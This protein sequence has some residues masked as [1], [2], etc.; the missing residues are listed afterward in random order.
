MIRKLQKRFYLFAALELLL[1]PSISYGLPAG[2]QLNAGQASISTIA[3]QTTINQTSSKAVIDWNS[4]NI[5]SSESVNFLQPSSSSITLNRIHDGSA[6]AINGQLSANGNIWLLNPNGILFGKT[7][8]VNVGGLLATTSNI[9]NNSFLSGDYNFTSGGNLSALI[10]NE[11]NITVAESGLATIVAPNVSNSG[12]IQ[13]RLGKVTLA[14]GDSFTLDTYGDNLINLQV[15]DNTVKK[16][17]ANHGVIKAD[18]GTVTLTAAGAN[19]VVNS[20]INMDGVIEADSVGSHN[21]KVVLYAEGSNAVAGNV[22]SKK[23]QKSGTSTVLVSGTIN[24]TGYNGTE[25][26]GTV[27]VLGDNVGLLSG[28]KIDVSGNNGGGTIRIG[29]PLSKST[30]SRVERRGG[31]AEDEGRPS[32]VTSNSRVCCPRKVSPGGASARKWAETPV[33]SAT[34]PR[35]N[36]LARAKS[37]KVRRAH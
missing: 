35:C 30:V 15:S 32:T 28:T 11:G 21:G 34:P 20:L 10:S 27:E 18:G 8:Q 1:M 23:N 6:S 3:S 25:T 19:S 4:F 16:V 12:L 7:A 2:G 24:A 13:A 33:P 9:N 14:S 29:R 31:S 37:S 36:P 26:G 5:S 17:V 22:P